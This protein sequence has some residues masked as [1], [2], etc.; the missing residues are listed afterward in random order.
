MM[1]VR[2]C[3]CVG[4]TLL[5][6]AGRRRSVEKNKPSNSLRER[7][8]TLP[9]LWM[10][11]TSSGPSPR[12][13]WE[14]HSTILPGR[15]RSRATR[16]RL[17]SPPA[18][19]QTAA[20]P[21]AGPA[22]APS[23]NIR[24]RTICELDERIAKLESELA[25]LGSDGASGGDSD[26]D[27]R[28]P[29]TT[30]P[31]APHRKR[32]RSGVKGAD[33]EEPVEAPGVVGLRCEMCG[34]SVTSQALSPPPLPGPARPCHGSHPPPPALVDRRCCAS[35]CRGRSTCRRRGRRRRGRRAASARFA[36]SP[37]PAWLS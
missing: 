1:Y 37:S 33:D 26:G 15:R 17:A 6:D 18:P 9:S 36:T 29:S 35:T 20:S 8:A 19:V 34:V 22:A 28:L 23:A 14:S 2:V 27:G 5:S 30:Q 16:P 24:R 7:F 12:P 13:W 31:A 10:A 21:A 25:E 11:S 4:Q 3:A 32:G